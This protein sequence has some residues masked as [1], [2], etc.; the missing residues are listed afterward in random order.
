VWD[1]RWARER[2]KR[3]PA[4]PL[5]LHSISLLCHH[6]MLTAAPTCVLGRLAVDGTCP[7]LHFSKYTHIDRLQSASHIPITAVVVLLVWSAGQPLAAL[8]QLVAAAA[9]GRPRAGG[10]GRL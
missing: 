2:L 8:S 9:Q 7:S 3:Q 6:Q 10:L 5:L 4:R 1:D